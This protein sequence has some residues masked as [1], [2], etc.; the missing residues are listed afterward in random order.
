MS[1]DVTDLVLFAV[2]F[3]A[4]ILDNPREIDTGATHHVCVDKE[5]FLSYASI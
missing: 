1:K 3:E 5:M 2:V 4:N